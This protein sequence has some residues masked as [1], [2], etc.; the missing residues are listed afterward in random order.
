VDDHV[1]HLDGFLIGCLPAGLGPLT[2]DFT[3]EWEDVSHASRVWERR[4]DAGNYS[5]D[6]TIRV[7][8][9]ERLRDPESLVD[10]LAE[11][12]ERDLGDWELEPFDVRGRTGYHDEQ[13]A[14]WLEAPG[15]A[16]EVRID[17]SRFSVCDLLRTARGV[18]PE[19]EAVGDQDE[20]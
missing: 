9:G 13:S 11:Y 8:R 16:V 1:R 19:P 3:F 7:M 5:V 6:L 12:H 15:V 18:V 2:S 14:F 17:P 4:D 10:Y 20:S